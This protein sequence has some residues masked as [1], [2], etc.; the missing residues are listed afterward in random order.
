MVGVLINNKQRERAGEA[1]D[2][3]GTERSLSWG[4]EC[5][6]GGDESTNVKQ[7]EGRL[8]CHGRSSCLKTDVCD[9]VRGVTPTSWG[10]SVLFLGLF[11]H[12]HNILAN[13]LTTRR[14]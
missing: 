12:L 3:N 7:E 1:A 4:A 10:A 2:L 5:D 8:R 11:S 9:D 6:D 13:K 14:A